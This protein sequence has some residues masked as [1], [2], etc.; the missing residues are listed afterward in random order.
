MKADPK[1]RTYLVT[2][3]NELIEA[4][5][6]L[7]LNEKR[8]LLLGISKINP[9]LE[10][11]DPL[12]FS[13]TVDDWLE[14]FPDDNQPWRTL[15]LAQK[16]LMSRGVIFRDTASLK[17]LS[18]EVYV[19]WFE[20]AT[21]NH[22]NCSI[23]VM[24][25]GSMSF[26]LFEQISRFATISLLELTSLRS[27]YSIR[28]YEQLMQYKYMGVLK[29]SVEDFRHSMNC[30]YPRL[31]DLKKR[32][33]NP[34]LKDIEGKTGL[35]VTFNQIKRGRT[36]THFVFQFTPEERKRPCDKQTS[37]NQ[38]FIPKDSPVSYGKPAK[39]PDNRTT[40]ERSLAE[41]YTDRSWAYD[42][43]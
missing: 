39:G 15:R 31:T 20:K 43:R 4:S 25:T 1:P 3:G 14:Y 18:R 37:G 35:C 41:D 2:Q 42:E 12:T 34:A 21:F 13:I 22:I 7:H 27:L 10:K 28:L 19:N 8:V 24:F 23:D 11:V 40:R 38:E 33:L 36:V 16:N 6:K 5:Q 29:I 26:Y 30:D 32:V 17:H 9:K